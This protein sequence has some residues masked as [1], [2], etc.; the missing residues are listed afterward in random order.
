L[1]HLL[2]ARFPSL[3]IKEVINHDDCLTT[4][5]KFKPDI[6]ILGIADNGDIGLKNLQQVRT[7]FPTTVIVLFTSYEMEEYR[8]QAIMKGANHIIS[9]ELWTGHEILA[10]MQTLLNADK[11]T[12][13]EG[14]GKKNTWPKSRIGAS[15]V[16]RGKCA[17]FLN[18]KYIVFPIFLL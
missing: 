14:R 7:Q 5:E 6:L 13:K 17:V 3:I 12:T 4:M 10:L 11:K 9:K 18:R 15:N 8:K 16:I 1:C 2:Q